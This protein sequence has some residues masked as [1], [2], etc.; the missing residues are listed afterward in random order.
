MFEEVLN[1]QISSQ[2]RAR[3]I[4]SLA[5]LQPLV[6]G[7][8]RSLVFFVGAGA[9]SAG[10]TGMPSTQAL[11]RQLLTDALVG[12]GKFSRDDLSLKSAIG[13]AAASSG[14]ETTLNDLW[15]ICP[16]AITRFFGSFAA[17]EK[18]CLPNRAHA[19]SAYWLSTG[20]TVVTTNYD[21]LIEAE[22]MNRRQVI[23]T[24]YKETGNNSFQTW[25]RDLMRGGCLFK[26]HGSLDE[27]ESCLG[28]LEHVGTRLG[29]NR[30]ALLEAIVGDRPICFVGW[31]G[32]DPDIPPVL[33]ELSSGRSAAVPT[34]WIHYHGS[35]P[36]S[37]DL[38]TAVD[39]VSTQVR[40]FALDEPVLADADGLF[41]G[42]LSWV[43]AGKNPN[44]HRQPVTPALGKVLEQCSRSG[45]ARFAGIVLRR[46]RQFTVAS[47]ALEAAKE[48][49]ATTGEHRAA[50]LEIAQLKWSRNKGRDKAEALGLVRSVGN[51]DFGLLSMTI[52]SIKSR[53]WRILLVPRLF[54]RYELHIQELR[55]DPALKE[56][57]ALHESLINLY[58]GRLRLELFGWL[59]AVVKSVADWILH[60]FNVARAVID[61]AGDIHIHSRIDVLAYRAVALARF[62]RCEDAWQD[63]R[64]ID[65]LVG[66]LSDEAKAV[67]WEHQRSQ[68]RQRCPE[69]QGALPV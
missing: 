51:A 64:E 46:A 8:D 55:N 32:A 12:S 68:L 33:S 6:V 25:Q 16:Q 4:S 67:H 56:S 52:L 69:D 57:A 38:H 11:L 43:G 14:F 20:G 26:L 3:S 13:R 1:S 7:K 44:P 48:L 40:R 53:P 24:R 47:T 23:R 30:A 28:A 2:D 50:I 10:N 35:P 31:R 9:S 45:L 34:L 22:W 29:G 59:G 37:K 5:R 18:T 65:R 49:A 63:V 39:E 62:G 19:F 58:S 61:D 15:Q 54:R 17:L 60:P 21:R 42:L 41:G 36:G 27:P 66:I